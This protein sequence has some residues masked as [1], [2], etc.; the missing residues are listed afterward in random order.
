V[1][2]TRLS[3]TCAVCVALAAGWPAGA[4]AAEP[5]CRPSEDVAALDQYCD[6]LPSPDGDEQPTNFAAEPTPRTPVSRVLPTRLVEMLR[7]SGPAGTAL[8]LL[9]VLAPVESTSEQRRRIRTTPRETLRSPPLEAP[10]VTPRSVISGV[11]GGVTAAGE[12]ALA[13]VFRW[14]LL[15]C[16]VGFAGMAWLRFRMRLKP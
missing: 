2:H 16:T 10:K 1:E 15:I 14:G 7:K 3:T 12:R 5:P 9:P 13:G 8:L 4:H 11:T 6:F